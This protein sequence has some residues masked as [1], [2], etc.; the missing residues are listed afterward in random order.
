MGYPK[1]FV[2][3]EL[4]KAVALKEDISKADA[5]DLIANAFKNFQEETGGLDYDSLQ[6]FLQDEFGLE[7]DF[8]PDLFVLI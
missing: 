8:I 5:A 1:S 7:P 2:R 4:V 3:T 6:D